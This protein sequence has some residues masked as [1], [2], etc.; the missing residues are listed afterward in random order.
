DLEQTGLNEA[1]IEDLILKT[2]YSRG[3]V[4]GRDLAAAL[5]LKFSLI[6]RTVDQLKRQRLIQANGSLGFG[7][8]SA[9]FG[10]SEAGRVRVRESPE[11]NQYI[12][13]APVPME[14]YA[15]AVRQQRPKR[16]WLTR[17]ALKQAYRGMIVSPRVLSQIG[18]AVNSGKS[19]LIYGQPGNG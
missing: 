5:G 13:P 12:G 3:E 16:G 10:V 1:V 9:V 4:I 11:H 6:E 15:I 8:I 7:S 14:Q 18:P 17:E 19:F 2:I